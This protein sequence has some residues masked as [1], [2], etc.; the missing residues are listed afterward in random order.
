MELNKETNLKLDF[1]I[2]QKINSYSMDRVSI[3]L[4]KEIPLNLKS[5]REEVLQEITELF[6]SLYDDIKKTLD[7]RKDFYPEEKENIEQLN[8]E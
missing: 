4:K 1:S 6:K 7:K 2:S 5:S 8:L 3:D